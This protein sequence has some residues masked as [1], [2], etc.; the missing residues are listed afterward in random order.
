MALELEGGAGD[1]TWSRDSESSGSKSIEIRKSG[2]HIPNVVLHS[3]S[4][5][6]SQTLYY[7]VDIINIHSGDLDSQ[8]KDSIMLI[9]LCI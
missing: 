5:Q 2:Y 9:I 4:N 1:D 7:R 6:H 8:R 3:K